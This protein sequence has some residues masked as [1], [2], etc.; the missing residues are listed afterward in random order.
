MSILI[1]LGHFAQGFI[2]AILAREVLLRRLPLAPGK[3]LFFLV[4]SVCL[5]SSACYE[6]IE[7][8]AAILGGESAEAFLGTQGDVWDTQWDMLLALMGAIAA[9][10]V[11][12]G[13]HDRQLEEMGVSK[14]S[15]SQSV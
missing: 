1:P 6:L 2:P 13:I 9:Q 15:M 5:A 4:A 3:G 10:A 7:W 14:E 8:W 11:F 12:S